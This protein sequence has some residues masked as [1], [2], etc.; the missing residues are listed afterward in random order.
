MTFVIF[1]LPRVPI[2][3]CR[4]PL[5]KFRQTVKRLFLLLFA[6]L[7]NTDEIY[8]SVRVIITLHSIISQ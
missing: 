7:K 3:S 2:L 8:T 6:N 1:D 5:L 4:L